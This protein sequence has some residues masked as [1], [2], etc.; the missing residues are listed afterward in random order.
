MIFITECNGNLIFLNNKWV[1]NPSTFMLA[2]RNLFWNVPPSIVFSI[3]QLLKHF[4]GPAQLFGGD[5]ISKMYCTTCILPL[6]LVSKGL[7]HMWCFRGLIYD[8]ACVKPITIFLVIRKISGC[9]CWTFIGR[10]QVCFVSTNTTIY[11]V[12]LFCQQK[13]DLPR[14]TTSLS[15]FL[16]MKQFSSYDLKWRQEFYFCPWHKR[17]AWVHSVIKHVRGQQ[18]EMIT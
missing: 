2:V 4:V 18:I 5:R 16:P 3:T 13:V 14:N 17:Q 8:F 12:S 11:W 1:M 15:I 7:F 6:N 10:Q 9:W